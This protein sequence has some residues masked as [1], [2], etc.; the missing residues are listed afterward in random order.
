MVSA[1]FASVALHDLR[2]YDARWHV[3][4]TTARLDRRGMVDGRVMRRLV[5]LAVLGSLFSHSADARFRRRPAR[6]PVPS[7][8]PRTPLP[9]PRTDI[10]DLAL[11]A[12]DCARS[13]GL[14]GGDAL[15]IIDYTLPSTA[16][17]LWVIDVPGRRVLFNELV[18]HG[19]ASGDNYAAAFSNEPGSR[20]SSLGLFRTEDTY[21]GQHGESLRLSGLEPGINDRAM[22]RAIVIHGAPYV[23][24]TF[25]AARGELGRS[26]GCPALEHGVER[27]VIERIKGGTALFAYYPDSHWLRTSRFLRCDE[28]AGT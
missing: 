15:T 25:I 6:F 20:Q 5:A 11:K 28:R 12:Y 8:V 3:R 4:A 9:W 1:S 27:R 24:P 16:R 13:A 22:E 17:R 7:T 19:V 21:D 10:L 18:A 2:R 23:S 14:V 26:W